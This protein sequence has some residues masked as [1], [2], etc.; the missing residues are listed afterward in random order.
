M[1]RNAPPRSVF[2]LTRNVA[3]LSGNQERNALPRN[4]SWCQ[5][6]LT[7]GHNGVHLPYLWNALNGCDS[8][9]ERPF[10][11]QDVTQNIAREA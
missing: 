8:A 10:D 6:T 3:I 2:K 5:Y 7:F 9:K 11:F 4:A 1:Q